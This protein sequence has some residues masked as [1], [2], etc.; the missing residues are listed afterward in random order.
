MS[1]PGPQRC[2]AVALCLIC[3][4]SSQAGWQNELT[5]PKPGSF[6]LPPE[7]KLHYRFG[8][9]P[10]K[11]GGASLSAATADFT[12]SHPSPGVLQTK[13]D[14][15]TTGVVRGL[16]KLDVAYTGQADSKTLRPIEFKQLETYRSEAKHTETTFTNT[17]VW[18]RRYTTPTDPKIPKMKRFR[19]PYLHSL[20]SAFFF[21]RSQRLS[22]G[23]VYKFV[24][25][26]QTTAYLATMTVT[27]RE[28]VT[29]KAG[30]FQAITCDFKLEEVGADQQLVPHQKFTNATLWVSDDADRIPLKVNSEI[31]VGSVMLELERQEILKPTP[32]M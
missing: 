11:G 31:F 6:P 13:G 18:R 10:T 23:D 4:Y 1:R 7:M 12:F 25:F 29:V 22:K 27:G 32:A 28:P 19:F 5:K 16:W 26:P 24:V 3:S 9:G 21:I 14:G 8:W 20:D 30:R 2:L 15:A 17:E